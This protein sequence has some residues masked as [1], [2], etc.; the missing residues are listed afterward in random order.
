MRGIFSVTNLSCKH[1]ILLCAVCFSC[2][3]L[4]SAPVGRALVIGLGTQED[5][6]WSKIN[7]D[8]DVGYVVKML[9][10]RKYTDIKTLK[11]GQATK[12]GIVN[13][14]VALANRCGVG[15]R[16]Y[17]HYSGHGQLVT[18]L[19]GDEAAR[20]QGWHANWD[21]SLIPYDAYMV[22]CDRDR[23]EKHL[24]DDELGYY[25]SNIRS[26]VGKRGEII[27][28]IDACHSGDATHG[29]AD[30]VV[31]GAYPKFSIPKN[32]NAPISGHIAEQWL[33]ISACQ[34][35]QLCAE[36]KDKRVGKLTFA[37]YSLGAALFNLNN[38]DMERYLERFV[39]KYEGRIPQTPMVT[40]RKKY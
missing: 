6:N 22:Y 38:E 8:N 32:V 31:R 7:G 5:S 30:E 24:T 4:F 37:L 10:N 36:I 23:G 29:V 3:N 1:I 17:I 11:N 35:Y 9:E 15:D 27:V 20:W 39:K 14:L 18:D 33:T 12:Q 21:E 19:N 13:A 34:P 26:K 25:L 16:V 28:V 2:V 40:G